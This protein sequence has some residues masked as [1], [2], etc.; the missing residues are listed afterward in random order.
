MLFSMFV[1]MFRKSIWRKISYTGLIFG[2][3]FM[4]FH[5]LW[6]F[7][8]CLFLYL[9]TFLKNEEPPKSCMDDSFCNF[10][11]EAILHVFMTA[12]FSPFSPCFGHL[13]FFNMEKSKL[14]QMI[15]SKDNISLKFSWWRIGFLLSC[16]F[17][18]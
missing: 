10:E 2:L 18:R 15:L 8:T 9:K 6:C 11:R 5:V 13:F 3:S 12:L 17:M 14:V 16:W 7:W 4:F 1:H